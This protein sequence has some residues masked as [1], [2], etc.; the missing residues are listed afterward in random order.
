MGTFEGRCDDTF[1]LSLMVEGRVLEV[2]V[3]CWMRTQHLSLFFKLFLPAIIFSID[4]DYCT[5]S[6]CG[7]ST[8]SRGMHPCALSPTRDVINH[9]MRHQLMLCASTELKSNNRA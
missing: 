8:C 4:R 7:A 5:S 6:R 3:M 2:T 1:S 9:R